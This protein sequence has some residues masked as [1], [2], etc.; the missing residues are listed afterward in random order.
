MLLLLGRKLLPEKPDVII[1]IIDS[2]NL[3]RNL[4]FTTQL[5][6]IGIPVVIAL[7][8]QDVIRRNGDRIDLEGLSKDLGCQAVEG[9]ANVGDGLKQL[10]EKVVATDLKKNA[11][12]IANL[13]NDQE[14]EIFIKD[15]VKKNIVKKKNSNEVTFSDKVDRI[16]A[17][18]YLGIPIFAVI[19]WGI[20]AFSINGFG[21]FL[22]GYINDSLFGEIIPNAANGFFESLGVNPLLQALI[23]I[24]PMLIPLGFLGWQMAAATLTG[25]IAKEN[26]VATFA[27]ILAA[28]DQ[29]LHLV[30]GPLTEL[31]TPVTAFA[32]LV[33]NLFTTP[34]FAAIGAMNTEYQSRKWL[35]RAVL[36]QLAVGYT[37]AM[38]ITQIGTLIVYG[39]LAVGFVPAIFMAG[40][41]YYLIKRSK[42]KNKTVLVE[43]GV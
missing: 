26:V 5:L 3:E 6:E 38:L 9:V 10:I 37:L 31:F 40:L 19:M 32:F 36:F 1:N 17:N 15:L 21:G 2:S 28:S 4:L 13:K 42:Y 12:K 8:K 43:E 25:F 22:S 14:R 24:A 29:A 27:I 18:A 20:Y 30:G 34:C 23:V 7:N 11:E 39:E 33:F 41:L 16:V 35:T